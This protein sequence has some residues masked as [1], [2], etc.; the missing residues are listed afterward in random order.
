MLAGLFIASHTWSLMGT[1]RFYVRS[2]TLTFDLLT[3]TKP[4]SLFLACI[5]RTLHDPSE[6]M[7]DVMKALA[8]HQVLKSCNCVAQ[9]CRS[10]FWRRQAGHRRA[11]GRRSTTCLHRPTGVAS[12][13]FLLPAKL[14]TPHVALHGTSLGTDG[15]Y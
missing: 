2:T 9:T 1:A 10:A 8:W 13:R 7:P 12:F 6:C 15:T 4:Q 14:H 5:K 11:A 3:L